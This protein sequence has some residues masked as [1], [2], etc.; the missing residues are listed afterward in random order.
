[1]VLPSRV[2]FPHLKHLSASIFRQENAKVLFQ[3]EWLS[4][5]N[6]STANNTKA[7]TQEHCEEG[8]H[9]GP[10]EAGEEGWTA[11]PGQPVPPDCLL[12]PVSLLV[13]LVHVFTGS[14]P[15]VIRARLIGAVLMGKD[16]M[17]RNSRDHAFQL[18]SFINV[19][20]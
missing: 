2:Q 15:G 20:T 12:K 7:H 1:M 6:S 19:E 14:G 18:P 4:N 8:Q 3:G 11:Q 13:V 16:T 9:V 5:K 17:G 10:G